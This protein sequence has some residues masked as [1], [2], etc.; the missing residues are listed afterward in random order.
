MY[1]AAEHVSL[2]LPFCLSLDK[3]QQPC[4]A[5]SCPGSVPSAMSISPAQTPR[6]CLWTKD[7]PVWL[8][9]TDSTGHWVEPCPVGVVHKINNGHWI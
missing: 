7:W 4:P 1:I 6:P 2:S 5:G 9:T 3:P 8:R